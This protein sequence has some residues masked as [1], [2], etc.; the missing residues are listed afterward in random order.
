MSRS[1]P[2]ARSRSLLVVCLATLLLPAVPRASAQTGCVPQ[3]SAILLG[4]TILGDLDPE[5]CIHNPETEARYDVYTFEA[6]AGTEYTAGMSYYPPAFLDPMIVVKDS[7]GAV[8]GQDDD[9]GI[10]GGARLHFTAPSSGTYRIETTSSGFGIGPYLVSLNQGPCPPAAAPI[11]PGQSLAGWLVEAD[12]FSPTRPGNLHDRYAFEATAGTAYTIVLRT[13]ADAEDEENDALRFDAYLVLLGPSGVVVA[14]DDNG[15][16]GDTARIQFVAAQT[17]TY[18]VEASSALPIVGSYQIEMSSGSCPA[19][20]TPIAVGQTLSGQLSQLDCVSETQPGFSD[21]FNF[22]ASAGQQYRITMVDDGTGDPVNYVDPYLVLRNASGTV[23]AEDDNGAGNLNAA[24][25]YTAQTSGSYRI[26][27]TSTTEGTGGYMLTLSTVMCPAPPTPISVGQ[28]LS[29][30]LETTDC[31]STARPGSYSDRFAFTATAGLQYQIQTGPP[32]GEPFYPLAIVRDPAGNTVRSGFGT[33]VYT[34]TVSGTF[35]IEVTTDFPNETG[36]Y[37]VSLLAAACPPAPTP[38]SENQPASGVL[39]PTDCQGEDGAYDR[40]SFQAVPERMYRIRVTSSVFDP[41]ARIVGDY[42]YTVF[43]CEPVGQRTITYKPRTA[44]TVIVEVSTYG[45]QGAYNVTL[46]SYVCTSANQEI[47]VGQTIEGSLDTT[48]CYSN[49]FIQIQPHYQDTY[50]FNATAGQAYV[51]TMSSQAYYPYFRLTN[52]SGEIVVERGDPF[53]NTITYTYTAPVSGVHSIEASSEIERWTGPYTLSLTAGAACMSESTPIAAGE[54]LSG[55][56]EADDCYNPSPR[57]NTSSQYDRFPVEMQA[58]VRYTI[59]MDS[60]E[61]E[62]MLILRRPDGTIA[63]TAVDPSPHGSGF[64][65]RFALML[66]TPIVSGTYMIDASSEYAEDYGAYTVTLTSNENCENTITP[67]AIGDTVSGALESTDCDSTVRPGAYRD[68]YTFEGAEGTRLSIAMDANSVD[69]F[70]VL[71]DP[72]GAVVATDDDSGVGNDARIVVTLPATGAYTIEATSFQTIWTGDYTLRLRESMGDECTPETG[73]IELNQTHYAALSGTECFAVSRPGSFVDNWQFAGAAGR[74]YL[75]TVSSNELDA[76]VA[77]LDPAGNVVASNDDGGGGLDA[78]LTFTPAVAGTYTIEATSDTPDVVGFYQVSMYLGSVGGT[79]CVPPATPLPLGQTVAGE[80]TYDDCYSQIQDGSFHDRFSFNAV[81]GRSYR[82]YMEATP[83]DNVPRLDPWLVLFLGDDGALV[84]G[85]DTDDGTN[86]AEIVFT[87]PENEQFTLEATTHNFEEV[88][89]YTVLVEE[90]VIPDDSEK[91]RGAGCA[92]RTLKAE[93]GQKIENSLLSTDCFAAE[94]PSSHQN[95]YTL[96]AMAGVTYTITMSSNAFDSRLILL[97][98]N[99]Q[100]AAEDDNGAGKLNARLTLTPSANGSYTILA[101]ST[102]V[103]QTGR[104]ELTVD[105]RSAE[106]IGVYVPASGTWFL[107]NSNTPGVANTTFV[108]GPA[109]VSWRALEGDWDGDGRATAGLYDPASGTFFLKSSNT[110]GPADVT[111]PFG[112]GGAAV[113]PLVG[114]WNGDGI[115]TVGLYDSATGTFFLRNTNEPGNADVTFTFGVGNGGYTPLA[116]D[117][118]GD[119][120]DSVGLHSAASGV[121]FLRN[122]S[123]PGN[124]DLSYTF[125]PAGASWRPIVGD[126]N[127]DGRSTVGLYDP[128]GGIFFLRNA[129]AGGPADVVFG[130]A[131]PGL[132]PVTGNWNGR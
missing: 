6:T 53:T 55:T 106:T 101:V 36:A 105:G 24:I 5:D 108:Y 41:R 42:G 89:P 94:R 113:H 58:G 66:F 82:V 10:D 118:D 98:P 115:D 85:D 27:A 64:P 71:T 63:E 107:R 60:T 62:T 21:L 54:T 46:E 75:I 30:A 74:P 104:Y 72:S 124:A 91:R 69:P 110:P 111:F 130:Y 92:P 51:I 32:S 73:T 50:T 34:P 26:E 103:T 78:S 87:A 25:V 127:A 132:V 59:R 33:L 128:A 52:P 129:H 9:G 57:W 116:G 67:I 56:L 95:R 16:V 119:G 84:Q 96:D 19:P 68:R 99:G 70:L 18:T 77:V 7:S 120:A 35:T 8:V 80:L 112:V 76:F 47:A 37:V 13:P 100:I 48:D 44:G 126:W 40:F 90:V 43:C 12:C 17:G 31:Y 20:A 93:P 39:S 121:F 1:S 61:V 86:N 15:G 81:A 29:G 23:V 4:Q 49:H 38:F 117:W 109:G 131:S 2:F 14:E 125:G 114:D 28:T 11:A 88:G 122:T 3:T 45:P 79:Q 97:G 123:S 22:T 83:I 65:D 102:G